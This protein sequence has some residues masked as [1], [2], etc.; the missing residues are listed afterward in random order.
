MA[1]VS[2]DRDLAR[3]E[4]ELE[5]RQYQELLIDLRRRE[6]FLRVFASWADVL[7]SMRRGTSRDPR[8]DEVLRPILAAH[9]A[10]QD[11]RWRTI[12]LVIFWPGL[13]ALHRRKSHWNRDDP[14]ELWQRIFWAFHETICRINL[15]RRSDR[16]AQ[17]IYNATAH[18]LYEGYERDWTRAKREL[19][20]DPDDL[21]ALAGRV[22]GIDIEGIELREQHQRAIQRLREHCEAGRISE[23]DCL[24]LIGTRLYG[25]SLR[26][27]ARGAGVKIETAKKR[28]QR[29][30][31]AIRRH[32][33]GLR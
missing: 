18:R 25:Q 6:P 24:L 29:A 33:K 10:D 23:A 20:T 9:A 27:Y 19:S 12:L 16:L 11:H 13:T 15:D 4:Q 7:T 26:E 21:G 32:D 8:K 2:W 1:A 14:E 5:T 22:D 30:E 3:L 28:R 31:A 17:W